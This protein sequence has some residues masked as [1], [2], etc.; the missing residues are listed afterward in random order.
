MLKKLLIL[1]CILPVCVGIAFVF[2]QS[3]QKATE[4]A[5]N[6]I[7]PYQSSTGGEACLGDLKERDIQFMNLGT[8]VETD[9]CTIYDAV[10]IRNFPNTKMSGAI[11]LN[12]QTAIDLFDWFE[13]MGA[14]DIKHMGSY[15]CRKIRGS[16]SFWSQ[17]SFGSAVDIS[18]INGASLKEDWFTDNDN[19]KYLKQAGKSACNYFA[20]VLTPDT[21]A[22]HHD[23]FHLD[24][25]PRFGSCGP[26]WINLINKLGSYFLN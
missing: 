14:K 24:N 18:H 4:K 20:N 15:N 10:K 13:E 22:A 6:G 9:I 21:N 2:Y 3:S 1:L 19:S 23:H 7:I 11:I 5:L 16:S 17:H 26:K 25:G 12:C 8:S